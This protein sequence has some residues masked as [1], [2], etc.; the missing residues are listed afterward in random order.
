AWAAGTGRWAPPASRAASILFRWTP[1]PFWA[2]SLYRRDDYARAG[3]PMLPVTHGE[4][5]TRRQILAYTVVLVASTLAVIPL[6]GLG[7][8]YAASAA[9]LG[10]L[11]LAGAERLRRKPSVPHA[12]SLFRYS[13]PSLFRLFLMRSRAA[14]AALGRVRPGRRARR[15][16]SGPE[17]SRPRGQ[18]VA[19]A[20]FEPATFGL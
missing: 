19:G 14:V 18:V 17:G 20:G 11:F 1:P 8:V 4:A 3:L 15:K 10:A 16:W 9:A 2:L 7:P 13:V 6:A 12:Q 5:E